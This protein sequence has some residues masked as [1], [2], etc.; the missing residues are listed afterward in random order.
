MS[1]QIDKAPAGAT[2]RYEHANNVDWYLQ[3]EHGLYRWQQG[4]W[5]AS[6]YKAVQDLVNSCP[7]GR[8]EAIPAEPAQPVEGDLTWLVR[9]TKGEWHGMAT[10]IARDGADHYLWACAIHLMA[11]YPNHHWFGK[12]K[13]LE[14]KAELQN[15][16]SWKDA[17]EWALS[18]TQRV[19]GEWFWLGSTDQFKGPSSSS[20]CVGEII[21]DWRDTLER[22]PV[23]SG[24]SGSEAAAGLKVFTFKATDTIDWST[25]PA[26]ATHHISGNNLEFSWHK[27]G[28]RIKY[29]NGFVWIK[30]S[31]FHTIYE[32]RA[33]GFT[34]VARPADLSD[35]AS[36]AAS[37][38]AATERLTE[39]TK[40]VLAAVPNLLGEQFKFEHNTKP[41]NVTNETVP[42][43]KPVAVTGT[44]MPIAEWA[45]RMRKSDIERKAQDAEDLALK[46][47]AMLREDPG[48]FS[49]EELA[50]LHQ[51]CYAE[52]TKRDAAV[53]GGE[54]GKKFVLV[55]SDGT[56][57]LVADNCLTW[58]AALARATMMAEKGWEK[59]KRFGNLAEVRHGK[60][61]MRAGGAV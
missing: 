1:N 60:L 15:K 19:N 16:P 46:L 41:V 39:A 11:E 43:D 14:C 51:L 58:T 45:E 36:S 3:A 57:G 20:G 56:F 30:R 10:H 54:H 40:N 32:A 44:G 47:V 28:Y 48:L 8:L 55:L 2:H 59:F 52:L 23:S 4:S 34:V 21:G 29:W 17:P 9:E 24:I 31:G 61:V 12:A 49:A 26:E 13:Y 27:N 33:K 42:M 22:R 50:D 35:V 38:A 37:V 5:C 25:A 18:V 6:V 7:L 53:C